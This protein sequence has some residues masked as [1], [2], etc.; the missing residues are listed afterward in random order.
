MAESGKGEHFAKHGG[1]HFI[2]LVPPEEINRFV[3]NLPEEKR[4]SMYEV[5]KELVAA[6]KISLPND[7]VWT[8][9]SGNVGGSDDC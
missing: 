2:P 4:D 9:G 6:G 5:M 7:G 8:D 3:E 1:V